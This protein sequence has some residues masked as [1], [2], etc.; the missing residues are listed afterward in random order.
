MPKS[1][2]VRR[3]YTIHPQPHTFESPHAYIVCTVCISKCK[4]SIQ[5]FYTQ[6]LR[7][8]EL[9]HSLFLIYKSWSNHLR[10]TPTIAR[11]TDIV[12]LCGLPMYEDICVC[13]WY[14]LVLVLCLRQNMTF[15][16]IGLVQYNIKLSIPNDTHTHQ[17]AV[18]C[19]HNTYILLQSH[20]I[21]SEFKSLLGVL[22]SRAYV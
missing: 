10:R 2:T 22:T 9:S 12:F 3:K 16:M 19:I 11:A 1:W 15:F 18:Y 4:Y 21:V 8:N 6:S 17:H 14:V 13:V 5:C 7:L 20:T